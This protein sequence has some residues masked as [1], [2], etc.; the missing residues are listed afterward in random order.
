MGRIQLKNQVEDSTNALGLTKMRLKNFKNYKTLKKITIDNII[1]SLNSDYS[2]NEQNYIHT[3]LSP[4]MRDRVLQVILRRKNIQNKVAKYIPTLLNS[5]TKEL[6]LIGIL[7]QPSDYVCLPYVDEVL[8]TA[9]CLAP[10][11]ERL[12]CPRAKLLWDCFHRA[13]TYAFFS[14]ITN[15]KKLQILEMQ[16]LLVDLPDIAFLCGNLPN[17]KR[18]DFKAPQQPET[19]VHRKQRGDPRGHLAASAKP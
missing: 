10:N 12:N 3:K 14:L 13:S 7:N 8:Y 4:E 2:L 11:L 16:R 5:H 19:A 1:K 6:N 9:A 17:L 18:R 15:F